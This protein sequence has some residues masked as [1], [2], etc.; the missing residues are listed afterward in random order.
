MLHRASRQN[1]KRVYFLE[2]EDSE[3]DILHIDMYNDE[4]GVAAA[5]SAMT[6]WGGGYDIFLL[7]VC[8]LLFGNYGF[9]IFYLCVVS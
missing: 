4:V 5:V 8:H 3:S 2:E 6:V 9:M 7:L 1:F